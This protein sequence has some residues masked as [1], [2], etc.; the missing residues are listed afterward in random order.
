MPAENRDR[1][2][3]CQAYEGT[4]SSCAGSRESTETGDPK[5]AYPSLGADRPSLGGCRSWAVDSNAWPHG[6]RSRLSALVTSTIWAGFDRTMVVYWSCLPNATDFTHVCNAGFLVAS[7][8]SRPIP[9]NLI[10]PI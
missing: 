2:R 7:A 4:K 5:M 6:K 1:R 3:A 10:S 8:D 9:E